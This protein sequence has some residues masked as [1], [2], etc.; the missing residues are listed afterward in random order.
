VEGKGNGTRQRE[1]TT[2]RMC[3]RIK[4]DHVPE[5]EGEQR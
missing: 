2:T 3:P 4:S 5:I 1:A